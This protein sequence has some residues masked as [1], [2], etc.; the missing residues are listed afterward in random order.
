MNIEG[1]EYPW[2]KPTITVSEI[3][4]L[5]NLP[6]DQPVICED[7]EGH[8]RTLGENETITIKRPSIWSCSELQ[9]D[10]DAR[11]FDRNRIAQKGIPRTAARRP[12]RLGSNPELLS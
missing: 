8:E 7:E 6:A 10:S 12:A 1:H 4:R 9:R 2:G 3:R 11:S 5:G